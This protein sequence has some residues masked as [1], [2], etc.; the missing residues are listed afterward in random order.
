MRL[1]EK[2]ILF[3]DRE[4]CKAMCDKLI[5]REIFAMIKQTLNSFKIPLRSYI[6]RTYFLIVIIT[7]QM[8]CQFTW[9]LSKPPPP[10]KHSTSWQALHQTRK[11]YE[12]RRL[13]RLLHTSM[14]NHTV[15]L[16]PISFCGYSV[17]TVIVRQRGTFPSKVQFLEL[18]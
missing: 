7:N 11:T 3:P 17:T 4:N 10:D 16:I 9:V 13:T 12:N 2:P 1:N 15:I 14:M 6:W 8:K 18:Q 5:I